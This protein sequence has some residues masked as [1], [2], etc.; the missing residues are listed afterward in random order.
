MD[1]EKAG[2]TL[3]A[4]GLAVVE[5]VVAQVPVTRDNL[6]ERLK[7]NRKPTGNVIAKEANRDAADLVRKGYEKRGGGRCTYLE[8]FQK[9]F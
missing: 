7:H 4:I 1:D 8:L 5:L 9:R 2:L 3:N 6:L